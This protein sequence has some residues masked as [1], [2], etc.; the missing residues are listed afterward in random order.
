MKRAFLFTGQGSQFA[1]MGADLAQRCPSAREVFEEADETL[2]EGLSKLCFEGPEPVLALTEN[3]QPATL[4][5]ALA[6]YRVLGQAPDLAA[7]HSVGEYTA[8]TAAGVFEF[9]DAIRLVRERGR[10]MQAAVAVG[11]GGMVAL[12]KMTADDAEQIVTRVD[13]GVCEIANRNAPEQTV[14]SGELAAM[15]QVLELVGPRKARRLPVSVPFHC[16]LLR[17]ATAGF[18]EFLATVEMRDPAFPVYCNADAR[19]VTTAAAA[20]DALGRQF[21]GPVLWQASIERM[22]QVEGV[23]AFVELGP[24]A[25]LSKM[26][27][28]IV[29]HLG[30][31][32]VEIAAVT[33]ADQVESL[34]V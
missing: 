24:K 22:L 16:S 29:G 28:Q 32:G 31:E 21:A 1:G 14:V 3:T 23:R 2:G 18:A 20:R 11:T 25:V 7:G 17:D 34:R 8:L 15:D 27:S 10:R 19:P 4:T 30:M 6:A 26:V 5:M 13:R 12:L 33:N 9:A